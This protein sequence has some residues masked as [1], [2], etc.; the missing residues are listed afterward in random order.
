MNGSPTTTAPRIATPPPGSDLITLGL[1]ATV[2]LWAM[3]YIAM[4]PGLT[5]PGF[6]VATVLSAGLLAAGYLAAT[7]A[8]RSWRGGLAIG[9]VCF[10][11]NLLILGSLLGGDRPGEV[12]TASLLWLAGFAVAAMTLAAAG[13]ALGQRRRATTRTATRTPPNWLA[14]LAFVTLGALVMLL[15]AGGVVTGLRAG[16]AFPDWPTTGGYVM[17]FYPLAMMRESPGGYAEHT[18][19]LWGMLVGLAALLLMVQTFRTDR[20]LGLRALAIVA[21]LA[22]CLQ[23]LMGGL[24]VTEISTLLAAVHGTFA[25]I[26]LSMFVAFAVVASRTWRDPHAATEH[27]AATV[28]RALAAVLVFVLVMQL[29]LGATIRHYPTS[30]PTFRSHLTMHLGNAVIVA[31]LAMIVG[32]RALGIHGAAH[33]ALKRLGVALIAVLMVQIALG[34]AALVVVSLALDHPVPPLADVIVTTAH[35]LT[36][37]ALLAVATALTCLLFRL[38]RKPAPCADPRDPA[39]DP[40]GAARAAAPPSDVTPRHAGHTLN[41]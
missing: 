35:Q 2:A 5:T 3:L 40:A 8:N 13:A 36:G 33:R 20:R 39:R 24:R 23:G 25:Q 10:L 27:P 4:M 7:L 16:M 41:A 15:L 26:V 6:I 31:M 30:S 32:V 12:V 22:V 14:V 29:A 11:V 34:L 19:R 18:H 21:F 9:F 1:G 17:V 28:D 38:V 37:A